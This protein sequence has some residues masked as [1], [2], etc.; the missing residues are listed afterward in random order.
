MS[1]VANKPHGDNARMKAIKRDARVYGQNTVI[2]QLAL[3]E[4]T[5][6]QIKAYAVEQG[7]SFSAAVRDLLEW[8]IEDYIAPEDA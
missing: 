4:I 1:R 6:E 7:Q 5:A 3:D 2:R 8:A